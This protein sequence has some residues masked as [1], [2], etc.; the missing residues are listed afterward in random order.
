VTKLHRK[1]SDKFEILLWYFAWHITRNESASYRF[2]C[3]HKAQVL[4]LTFQKNSVF[5]QP[6]ANLKIFGPQAELASWDFEKIQDCE[7]KWIYLKIFKK[8]DWPTPVIYA[9][10]CR[11]TRVTQDVVF[12]EGHS[13]KR[14]DCWTIGNM[15]WG[16]CGRCANQPGIGKYKKEAR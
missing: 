1:S 7:V 12:A 3:F 6:M 14:N 5:F 11:L 2:K 13:V 16:L 9:N 10:L 4:L 8:T 15:R